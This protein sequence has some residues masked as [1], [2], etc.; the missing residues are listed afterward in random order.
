MTRRAQESW[1]R[2]AQVKD[3]AYQYTPLGIQPVAKSLAPTAG[4][5]KLGIP[6]KLHNQKIGEIT[7]RRKD[8][9]DDWNPREK[10]MLEEIAAQIGL[11]LE[12]AR[13][14][15]DAQQRAIRERTI[16]EIAAH[17]GSAHDVDAILRMT[18]QEIG[19]AIGNSE[20]TVHIRGKDEFAEP[21]SPTTAGR[22]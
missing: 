10:A 13:L 4:D 7:V 19:K 21:N 12:N 9:T 18:A 22:P 15:D 3:I 6:I 11:A 8:K 2:L 16:S 17:I 20:V 14:L 1:K 5:G